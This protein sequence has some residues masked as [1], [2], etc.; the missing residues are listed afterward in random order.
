FLSQAKRDDDGELTMLLT[1]ANEGEVKFDRETGARY[2]ELRDG[3]RYVGYPGDLDYQV[4][5]FDQFGELIPEPE[6]GVRTADPVD[7]RTTLH[8]LRSDLLEDKAALHWR[9]SIPAMVP[10]VAIIAMCMSRTNHRRGRYIKMAPAFILYL[11]YLTLLANARSAIASGEGGPL[12]I[13]AVHI[14]FLAVALAMLYGPAMMG[15]IK[16][17]R[18]LNAKA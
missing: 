5:S 2:L 13:W 15:R 3:L 8:L 1:I 12:S 16:H 17:R 18:Y 6:G 9:L 10:I 7:G 11:G 4:V 14:L